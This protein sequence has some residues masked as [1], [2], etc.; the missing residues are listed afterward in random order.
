[1]TN[2]LSLLQNPVV[3]TALTGIV[4]AAVI[5]ILKKIPSVPL[6]QGQTALLRVVATVFSFIATA[7]LQSTGHSIFDPGLWTGIVQGGLTYVIA[8]L[9]HASVFSDPN[10]APV[11]PNV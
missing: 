1:M 8:Y 7:V 4:V 11:Q 3:L 6:N 2:L 5:Q 10:K 9:T